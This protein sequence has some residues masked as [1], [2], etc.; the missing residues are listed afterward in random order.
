MNG[1]SSLGT[2]HLG[3]RPLSKSNKK[4]PEGNPGLPL[5]FLSSKLRKFSL[6]KSSVVFALFWRIED[7]RSI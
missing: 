1:G 2:N 6:L 7:L 4:Y 5:S 3:I